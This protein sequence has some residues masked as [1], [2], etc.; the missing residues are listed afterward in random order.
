[1][2]GFFFPPS[3]LPFRLLIAILVVAALARITPAAT[4]LAQ[5]TG[6]SGSATASAAP[7]SRS[8]CGNS[9]TATVA[10]CIGYQI[11]VCPNGGQIQ[12]VPSGQPCPG[13]AQTP[14]CSAGATCAQPV[15]P[16]NCSSP[17]IANPPSS[18]FGP[19]NGGFAS[20]PGGQPPQLM[21]GQL[22]GFPAGQPPALGS[23]Q[24]PGGPGARLPGF[25]AGQTPALG[26][27]QGAVAPAA[28]QLCSPPLN[29]ATTSTP[30]PSPAP[31]TPPSPTTS[32]ASSP[33][34]PSLSGLTHS[35]AAFTS[36][37]GVTQ[38][39]ASPLPGSPIFSASTTDTFD[40]SQRAI[41]T[42]DLQL[43]DASGNTSTVQVASLD[44][45]SAVA[46]GGS[47]PGSVTLQVGDQGQPFGAQVNGA[48]GSGP[49]SGPLAFQQPAILCVTLP[50][51][52]V[53]QAHAAGSAGLALATQDGAQIP[54]AP[55]PTNAE[56]CGSVSAA[57]GFNV[58]VSTPSPASAPLVPPSTPG[59]ASG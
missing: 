29:L 50:Q 15:Q 8:A 58:T 6:C 55:P 27:A 59:A 10:V 37:P 24:G 25:A 35:G 30:A 45:P 33:A 31:A 1:M 19:P 56:V 18:Q 49:S 26:S 2:Y 23:G 20:G 16:S 13:A 47:G 3:S 32:T 52:L 7:C 57:G 36:M 44:I 42:A 53:D 40:A 41:V 5:S 43:T 4:S 34:S 17:G 11:Q 39:P 28:G 9:Q 51:Y 21:S 48:C 38:P 14:G 12:V 54:A 22:S 46:C